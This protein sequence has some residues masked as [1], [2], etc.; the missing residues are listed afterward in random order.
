[1]RNKALKAMAATA[2]TALMTLALAGCST[3][4]EDAGDATEETVVVRVGTM[5]TEDILPLWV[6]QDGTMAAADGTTVEVVPFDSAQALSAAITAGEVDMA[7]TDI[8][9][10]AKLTESGTAVDLEWVTLGETADQGVFGILAPA[11]APYDTLQEMAVYAADSATADVH[12][13]GVGANTVPEYVFN[14]LCAEAGV[15]IPSEEVASLPERYSL[16]ASGQL[17]GAAL[18]APLLALGEANGMK[19]IADDSQGSNISQSVMVARAEWAAQNEQAVL[20]VAEI[21][22]GAVKLL[23]DDP[24]AY[25][26]ILVTN[27]NLNETIAESYPISSYPRAL[28]NGTLAHPSDSMVQPVLDWMKT[29][30]YGGDISYDAATGAMSL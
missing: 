18:P 8:M 16:V 20:D 28:S 5:P 9:R 17:M 19:V 4:A 23:A 6:A 14:M 21:W 27:A 22:D 29:R 15:T 24:D 30:G 26:D 2:C 11:N 7:M 13:V 25:H 3:P 1:M 10:A 12:G